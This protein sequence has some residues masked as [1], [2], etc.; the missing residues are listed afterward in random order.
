[1]KE[2][3]RQLILRMRA[4]MLQKNYFAF[5]QLSA[6]IYDKIANRFIERRN[7]ALQKAAQAL[8]NDKFTQSPYFE[9]DCFKFTPLVSSVDRLMFVD[10]YFEIIPDDKFFD[11][12]NVYAENEPLSL[13]SDRRSGM[14]NR[15]QKIP[16][17]HYHRFETGKNR[18][19]SQQT[20][21][22]QRALRR[23]L[24]AR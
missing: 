11:E 19:R 18:H 2:S 15:N 21:L 16:P 13:A 24:Y 17:T 6:Y 10:E 7:I 4:L 22:R 14:E 20:H 9:L 23:I 3:Y 5:Q 12:F 1:M 8:G